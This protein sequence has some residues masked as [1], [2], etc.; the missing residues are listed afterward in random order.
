MTDNT[1]QYKG[2]YGSVD[3]SHAD[4]LLHGKLLGIKSLVSYEGTSI[5]ELQKEFKLAVDDYLEMCREENIDPEQPF[6]GSVEVRL[7]PDTWIKLTKTARSEDVPV[8]KLIELTVK[9]KFRMYG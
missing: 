1:M 5:P 2:Y 8:S 9:E 7:D 4:N 6:S 3:Y